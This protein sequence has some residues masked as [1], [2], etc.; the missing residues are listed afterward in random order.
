M[1][2]KTNRLDCQKPTG[3]GTN[4]KRSEAELDQPRLPS[5]LSLDGGWMRECKKG[6]KKRQETMERLFV[7][8]Q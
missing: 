5:L 7:S 3:S 2:D 1:A 8:D 4:E 6:R